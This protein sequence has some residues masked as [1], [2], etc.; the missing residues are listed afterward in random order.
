MVIALASSSSPAPLA[1]ATGAAC[2]PGPTRAGHQR[3]LTK[4]Y[5][6]A[7]PPMGVYA[8]RNLVNQR[9]LVGASL[10]VEGA[11]NRHRFELRMKQHRNQRLLQ[12]WLRDGADNFRFE[13]IDTLKKRDD[14]AFDCKSELATLL[15]MW[16]EEL[17]CHSER[18]YQNLQPSDQEPQS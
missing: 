16:S 7:G 15:A 3:E 14:P 6:E 12:D 4:Q 2:G 8:I 17:G 18:G 13:V 1:D 5:K 11:L 9:V 10:N